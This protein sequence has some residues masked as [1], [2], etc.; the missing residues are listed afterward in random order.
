MVAWGAT[1]TVSGSRVHW[2]RHPT[3]TRPEYPREI[4]REVNLMMRIRL[5]S[6]VLI[7]LIL[8]STA[9]PINRVVVL[10]DSVTYG[11]GGEGRDYVT[12]LRERMGPECEV[13]RI[14][15]P[16]GCSWN[17]LWLEE[18]IR[19]LRPSILVIYF[20]SNDVKKIHAGSATWQ[21]FRGAMERLVDLS[22]EI[23]IIIPH[24]GRENPRRNYYLEDLAEA[25]EILISL[26]R[27]T[28]DL[29]PVCCSE[30]ELMDYIHPNQAGHVLIAEEVYKV[31]EEQRRL[32]GF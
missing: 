27:P 7:L 17:G 13:I 4:P 31:I 16:G 19:A 26:K 28:V 18:A 24:R 22:S 1:L 3:G 14:G 30:D 11:A 32:A 20:G 25:R 5:E 10:G 2:R 8:I 6:L 29:Y 21:E 9:R 23:L 12:L 15:L